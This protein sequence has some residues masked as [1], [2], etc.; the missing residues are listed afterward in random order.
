MDDD[1]CVDEIL[2]VG[3]ESVCLSA[4]FFSRLR[5]EKT[6]SSALREWWW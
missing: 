6:E 4:P 2:W 5:R 1:V 3:M